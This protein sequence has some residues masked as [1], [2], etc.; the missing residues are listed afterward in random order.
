MDHLAIEEDVEFEY[1]QG[2]EESVVSDLSLCLVGR[3]LTDKGIRVSLMKDK[4]ADIW[5]PCRGVQINEVEPGL[6]LFQFYHHLDIQKVLK[7]GPWSFDK[8]LP[9][10][11]VVS[12]GGVPREI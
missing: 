5:R 3:F 2:E 10:L 9:I 8:H 4:M 11:G 6:F 1:A 12:V 7:Q